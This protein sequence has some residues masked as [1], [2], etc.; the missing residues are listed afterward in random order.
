MNLPTTLKNA[1]RD[2][3]E[4]PADESIT[5]TNFGENEDLFIRI[6]K[7]SLYDGTEP[8][9]LVTIHTYKEGVS[10]DHSWDIPVCG[11]AAELEKRYHYDFSPYCSQTDR[12]T[13]K[14]TF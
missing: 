12:I 9:N 4:L 2:A 13:Q 7:D 8:T 1:V 11:L 3:Y 6:Y 10:L 14:M 5:I